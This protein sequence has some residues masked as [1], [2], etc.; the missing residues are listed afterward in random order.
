MGR[1]PFHGRVVV[2]CNEHST[3][4]AE[5]PAQ[6]AKENHLATIVG[7]RTPGHLISRSAFP[8]SLGFPR[9]GSSVKPAQ[10]FEL[11]EE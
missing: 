2:L 4:A 11:I 8:I 6:F 5:M 10:K 7:V 1:Q 3:G 9:K